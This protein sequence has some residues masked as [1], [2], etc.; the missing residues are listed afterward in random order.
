[1]NIRS[2][3]VA[4]RLRA[5]WTGAVPLPRAFWDYAILAGFFVNLAAT[6]AS[7]ALV[8]A[9]LPAV[10]ALAVH[11]APLPYTVLTLVGVWRSAERYAGPPVWATLARAAIVLWTAV[12]VVL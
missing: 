3:P 10:I 9:G 7:M 4:G 8:V 6:A 1:M 2:L 11:F 5:L 12:L